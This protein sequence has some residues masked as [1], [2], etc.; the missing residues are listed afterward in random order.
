M[1]NSEVNV[2]ELNKSISE[3]NKTVEALNK[4]IDKADKANEES[5]LAMSSDISEIKEIL[6]SLD[7]S[8][9]VMSDSVSSYSAE[10]NY[11]TYVL[12]SDEQQS[13]IKLASDNAYTVSSDIVSILFVLC[14]GVYL[15]FGSILA[16]TLL[17]HI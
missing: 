13:Y 3:L 16:R 12:L 1:A 4:S 2:D 9:A 17:K 6:T 8:M 7:G 10:S 11:E 15:I 14:V 5:E